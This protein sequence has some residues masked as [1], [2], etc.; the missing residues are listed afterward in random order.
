MLY[1][2]GLGLYDEKD[3]SL[4]ATEVLKKS[5]EVYV[6]LY[7]S[8]F[9]GSLENLENL[10]GKKIVVLKRA[11]IEEKPTPLIEKA[12]ARDVS[13]LVPGDPMMATTHIDLVLRAEKQGVRTRIIH[14][15]SIYSAVG[16]TGLQLYKFGKTTTI[17]Y[18][19][20]NYFP[21]SPYD[22]LKENSERGL[23]TLML[24]DVKSEDGRYMTVNEAIGIM[25]QIEAVRKEGF[26]T[27]KTLCIG[28][29]RIGAEDQA[30]LYGPAGELVKQ[31]EFFLGK[32]PQILIVH[33]KL[34]YMEEE[35]LNRYA[36]KKT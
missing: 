28:A 1:L 36:I 17:A 10:T 14:A 29:A 23:H 9:N 19:E 26:F 5:D 21:Y 8:Y 33:G 24:L 3:L 4:R 13:I 20:K 34:H 25:L 7:T 31:T 11:D 27:E 18:P 22:A 32:P 12:R 30:I 6:E 35:A 15:S 2:I 16:E